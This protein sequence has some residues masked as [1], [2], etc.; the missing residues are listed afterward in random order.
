MSSLQ[1]CEWCGRNHVREEIC[2]PRPAFTRR[3]FFGLLSAGAVELAS[4]PVEVLFGVERVL[5]PE[6]TD[7]WFQ[8]TPIRRMLTEKQVVRLSQEVFN[9]RWM[10]RDGPTLQ[11][12][13]YLDSLRRH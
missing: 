13:S 5:T 12:Q 7:P 2:R 3:S 1:M 9:R 8:Q 10:R 6:I 4:V 11:P